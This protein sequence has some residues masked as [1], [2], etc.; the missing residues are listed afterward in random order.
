MLIRCSPLVRML[1]PLLAFAWPA[2]AAD[3]G[4][5]T[6]MV[7]LG[8]DRFVSGDWVMVSQSVDGDLFAAGR[9]L[10]L[11]A[12][13][14]G[15]V[16]A[17]GR[18]V[19]LAANASQD[20]YVAGSAVAISGQV[21]RNTRAAG[22]TVTLERPARVMGNLS[23]AG[24]EVRIDGTIAGYLQAA[25]RH[26]VVNGVV[27][28]DVELAGERIELG[29]QARIDGRL[30]YRSD[31]TIR[32]H[33]GARVAGGIERRAARG[34]Q[35]AP[36]ASAWFRWVWLAGS[37]IVAAVLVALLPAL[38]RR[39]AHAARS[40]FGKTLLIGLAALLLIPVAAGLSAITLV[41][42]PLA[43]LLV[44]SYLLLLFLG[45]VFAAIALGDAGLQRMQP[46]KYDALGW[47]AAAAA[48]GMAV[49][50]LLA[51][52]PVIGGIVALLALLI[53]M[54]AIV[55]QLRTPRSAAAS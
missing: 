38:T 43:V 2:H 39:S 40:R 34:W 45:F 22:A 51:Y 5:D 8:D 48:V 6:T 11:T 36:G 1:G 4:R 15:D 42:I 16:V 7:T 9:D 32:Q 28:G 13:V 29:P 3:G 24:R 18:R 17:A 30:R 12:P 47:R 55:A 53:G 44:L 33:A 23:A 27:G 54:G 31:A 52:I 50:V 20:A 41:G 46:G 14:G 10:D 35:G 37:M 49:L 19:R 26:I 21:Q 25:G